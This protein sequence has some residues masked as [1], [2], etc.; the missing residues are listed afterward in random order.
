MSPLEPYTRLSLLLAAFPN[1]VLHLHCTKPIV[2]EQSHLESGAKPLIFVAT[3]PGY[4]SL[5][6]M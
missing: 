3:L 2:N 5:G 6:Y 4:A 1:T